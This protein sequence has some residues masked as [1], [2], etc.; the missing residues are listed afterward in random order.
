MFWLRWLGGMLAAMMVLAF[1]ATPGFAGT[2]VPSIDDAAASIDSQAPPVR[3]V[4]VAAAAATGKGVALRDVGR[5]WGDNSR[6]IVSDVRDIDAAGATWIRM[7]LEPTAGSAAALG[8]A[9]QAAKARGIQLLVVLRKPPPLKDLG[10]RADRAAYRAFV[11]QAVARHK[12]SVRHWEINDEPNLSHNWTIDHAPASNQSS[13]EASVRRY[14]THLQD[15]YQTIKQ[16]DPKATVLFGGLSEWRVE[17]YLDVLV[18]TPAFKYFDVMSYHTYGRTPAKV[19]ARFDVIRN[20][21]RSVPAYASKPI[22]VTE[23]GYNTSWT[24]KGGYVKTEVL[25]A[26]YLP[27]TIRQLRAAGASGPCF[28]YTLHENGSNSSGYGLTL[29]NKE[30]L[31]TT[32]LPAFTAFRNFTK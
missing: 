19:V 31:K 12:A 11:R 30:T 21:M 23:W 32:R 9:V 25:K 20:K 29:K 13:Y 1:G 3:P 16:V 15:G 28:W 4:T 2:T 26:S 24:N 27:V 8:V 17:R 22:W 14:V 7:D 18:K 10:T 5:Y 6:G